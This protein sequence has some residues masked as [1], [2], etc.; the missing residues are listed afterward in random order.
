M[1][2][3]VE[4]SLPLPLLFSVVIPSEIEDPK[5]E[6][7]ANLAYWFWLVFFLLGY[8][9]TSAREMSRLRSTGRSYLAVQPKR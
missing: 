7:A 1:L 9:R 4:A 8:S 6:L 3:E 2:I 5:K